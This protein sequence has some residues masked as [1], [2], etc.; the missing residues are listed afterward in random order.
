MR[1]ITRVRDTAWFEVD[2]DNATRRWTRHYVRV[3]RRVAVGGLLAA[4]VACAGGGQI[5][6]ASSDAPSSSPSAPRSSSTTTTS[7]PG[8]STTT[9]TTTPT[10]Q[11]EPT[12]AVSRPDLGAIFEVPA[13]WSQTPGYDQSVSETRDGETGYVSIAAGG[14]T[15]D[16]V[17][18]SSDPF[19]AACEAQANSSD[20]FYGSSPKLTYSTVDEHR[21]CTVLP[22]AD[23]PASPRHPSGPLFG[24]AILLVEY[25][26]PIAIGSESSQFI[27]LVA[28]CDAEHVAHVAA[29]VKFLDGR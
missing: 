12:V 22:S 11:S 10:L 7:A 6:G 19:V 3:V 13:A 9:A 15:M 1:G 24:T 20:G 21:A 28:Y 29:S 27:A 16:T 8:T 25:R 18:K 23:A 5:S 2:H 17:D 4:L 26:L 14:G